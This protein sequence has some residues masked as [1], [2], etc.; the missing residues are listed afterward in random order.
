MAPGSAL[1]WG[2]V[3]LGLVVGSGGQGGAGGG[4]ASVRI[5]EAPNTLFTQDSPGSQPFQVRFVSEVTCP[6][7]TCERGTVLRFITSWDNDPFEDLGMRQA[8]TP[9]TT[10]TPMTL[11]VDW[12][13]ILHVIPVLVFANGERLQG[14]QRNVQVLRQEPHV[15]WETARARL[16]ESIEFLFPE[17]DSVRQL[18]DFGRSVYSETSQLEFDKVVSAFVKRD[19]AGVE[20][21]WITVR[22]SKA[23]YCSALGS[24]FVFKIGRID[25]GEAIQVSLLGAW[26]MP[27]EVY[28]FGAPQPLAWWVEQGFCSASEREVDRS[29]ALWK[30]AGAQIL[31]SL[32]SQRANS[33]DPSTG[34]H[35]RVRIINNRLSIEEPIQ[36]N[37]GILEK[38]GEQQWYT[39]ALAEVLLSLLDRFKVPDVDMCFSEEAPQL[40][41]GGHAATFAMTKTE[42]HMDLVIPDYFFRYWPP[43]AANDVPHRWYKVPR[44]WSAFALDGAPEW[45]ARIPKVW[46]R[47]TVTS[48]VTARGQLVRMARNHPDLFD[49][50]ALRVIGGTEEEGTQRF[51]GAAEIKAGTNG[52]GGVVTDDQEQFKFKYVISTH[53]PNIHWANRFRSLLS[54]GALVFKQVSVMREFWEEELVPFEHYI[55]VSEDLS[56]LI[57]K[58]RWAMD[59]DEEARRIARAGV[60]F[61][62][63]RLN[64]LRVTCY[65][66]HMLSGYGGLLDRV[67]PPPANAVHYANV[68]TQPPFSRMDAWRQRPNAGGG[69][70]GV[71]V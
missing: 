65:W 63:T 62:R 7:E 26:G 15:G 16:G 5:V 19:A 35:Q 44:D 54:T 55:P 25:N 21:Y 40:L 6:P 31:A 22:V 29:L 45:H 24:F 49:A 36:N 50:V 10:R 27:Q 61:I 9:G 3:L 51:P 69:E 28:D 17:D 59:N 42:V 66:A 46:W 11:G 30:N 32:V 48:W 64:P 20:Y 18:A 37:R 68:L 2:A 53:G 57:E 39:V 38:G 43:K 56:D 41:K 52:R 1:L 13:G 70:G 8:V 67:T 47:G 60:E 14:D 33:S 34:C 71:E 58:I 23:T 4:G 12:D